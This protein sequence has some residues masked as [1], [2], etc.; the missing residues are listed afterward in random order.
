MD[1]ANHGEGEVNGVS[2]AE[3]KGKTA[4]IREIVQQLESRSVSPD[5]LDRET[6]K[7]CIKFFKV[8]RGYS[9]WTIAEIL[10]VSVR[11]VQRY[12]KKIREDNTMNLGLYW[13]KN[14]IG[15]LL[16]KN[17]ARVQRLE[18][19][20]Y[21]KDISPTNI[22]K[23]TQAQD[24]LERN[25]IAVLAEGG[26]LSKEQ[27]K[28]DLFRALDD[29]DNIQKLANQQETDL[30]E[31]L[32]KIRKQVKEIKDAEGGPGSQEERDQLYSKL[33]VKEAKVIRRLQTKREYINKL[34]Q[35][36]IKEANKYYKH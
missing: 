23:I 36:K 7:A 21:L 26:Y 17:R 24:Q 11:T 15:E 18:R 1:N 28:S 2:P 33:Q 5:V 31:D 25:R 6:L 20:L 13:Q 3:V 29:E 12:A 22:I 14:L 16:C 9:G 32:E 35:E 30:V 34:I 10:H 27:G 4:D 19:L 8:I